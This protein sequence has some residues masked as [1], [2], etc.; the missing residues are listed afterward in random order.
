MIKVVRKGNHID[1]KGHALFDKYGKDIVCAAVSSI[2]ITTVN[3]ILSID[4][5]SIKRIGSSGYVSIDI[6]KDDSVVNALISNMINLLKELE[7]QYK[8]NIQVEEVD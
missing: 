7:E 6:I 8:K 3:G 2:V 5:G 1:I 4:E